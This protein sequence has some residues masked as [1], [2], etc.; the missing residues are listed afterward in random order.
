MLFCGERMDTAVMR[1]RFC[2]SDFVA[3]LFFLEIGVLRWRHFL[4][5]F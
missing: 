2:C 5:F 3:K 4:M 1:G